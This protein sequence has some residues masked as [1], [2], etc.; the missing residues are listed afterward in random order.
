V[1]LHHGRV[2]AQ[3]DGPGKGSTFVFTTVAPVAEVPPARAREFVGLQPELAGKRVLVVDDNATNRRILALQTAKWGMQPRD[4]ESPRQ[5]LA[6]IAAGELRPCGPHMH[7]PGMDGATLAS[8]IRA[9]GHTLPLVLFTSLGRREA[10]DGPFEP[11]EAA[12]PGQ[13]SRGHLSREGGRRLPRE[14]RLDPEMASTR[15]ASFSPR[16]TSST[17]SSRCASSS[18]WATAPISPATAS[19][20]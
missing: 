5:A 15:C 16:T 8:R 7:M 1:R 20:P 9:A 17:R 14:A 10:A 2:E 13:P 11:P 18:R 12:A 6:W 4:T 3:S 19:K